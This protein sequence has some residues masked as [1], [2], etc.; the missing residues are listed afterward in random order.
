MIIEIDE[1]K[2]GMSHLSVR[3]HSIADKTSAK[4]YD[5]LNVSCACVGERR[6]R[7]VQCELCMCGGE[8]CLWQTYRHETSV[9]YRGSSKRK[10]FMVLMCIL[11]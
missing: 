2:G 1:G 5:K 6:L 11:D 9:V 3:L 8:R 4:V 7:Q 10:C